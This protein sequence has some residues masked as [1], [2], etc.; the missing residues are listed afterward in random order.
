ME[1]IL[2]V[3]FMNIIHLIHQ[4]CPI[5]SKR[6]VYR[7][8]KAKWL[9]ATLMKGL[10]HCFRPCLLMSFHPKGTDNFPIFNNRW[11]QKTTESIFLGRRGKIGRILL[12]E[13]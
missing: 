7:I 1:T 2:E 12:F 4:I 9:A 6:Q 11:I 8:Q 13:D 3:V 5:Y 10:G